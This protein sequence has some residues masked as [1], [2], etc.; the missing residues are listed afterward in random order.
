MNIA[1]K[2]SHYCDYYDAWWQSAPG[3]L[4]P[5]VHDYYETPYDCTIVY[6]FIAG[7]PSLSLMSMHHVLSELWASAD[8]CDDRRKALMSFSVDLDAYERHLMHCVP[9]DN[10]DDAEWAMKTLR[11]YANT[12]TPV[13]QVHGDASQSNFVHT[14]GDNPR[15]V[16]IDPGHHRGL[17]VKELDEAKLLQSLLGF[18]YVYRHFHMPHYVLLPFEVT[19]CHIALL[20]TH[21]LRLLRH[22]GKNC[23]KSTHF[24]KQL[25]SRIRHTDGDVKAF[26]KYVHLSR[27][28][29][30]G[31]CK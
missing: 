25:I 16:M 18:E 13:R 23:A 30:E 8:H 2:Y 1:K 26:K 3:L 31:Y 24:A 5:N 19:R 17:C 12:L 28:L 10:I 14:Y 21:L 11:S 29:A 6:D 22:V 15:V 20:V 27:S 4:I 9:A 7:R